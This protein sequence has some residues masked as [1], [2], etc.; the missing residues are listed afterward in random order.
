[1]SPTKKT[2]AAPKKSPRK[3]T[4]PKKRTAKKK[5]PSRKTSRDE[6][7]SDSSNVIK[8]ILALTILLLFVISAAFTAIHVFKQK[9]KPRAI[10]KTEKLK[11]NVYHAPVF[12]VYP[13]EESDHTKPT[14]TI[15]APPKKKPMVS[16]IIDDLGYD[17]KIARKFLKINQNITFSILPHSPHQK[18]IAKD[19]KNNGTEILLH[20]PME[21]LKYPAI[22][23]GPGT[24]FSSMSPDELIKQ[25][26][27]NLDAVPFIIGV[28]NHMGSKITT[29]AP[30]IYQVFSILK[31]RGLFF[32][33]SRTTNKSVC[34][35]SAR[36][37][38]IPF[39]ERSVFLDNNQNKEAVKKQLL[40]L[41]KIAMRDGIAVGI[42]H[43]YK[44]TYE[45]LETELPDFSKKVNL[46]PIS[47]IIKINQS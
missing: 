30:Q 31:K 40:R 11:K 45:V 18:R 4:P 41:L 8:S 46:V 14:P 13:D 47:H 38:K 23:S 1:M 15:V 43:P 25:L 6:T 3:K 7:S 17:R 36:L 37:F 29:N 5:A 12:E 26:E 19:A 16:I 28:N 21:P 33:D 24:L 22:D 27:I 39:A 42:G 10:H 44:I 35:P 2:K 9:Q 32:I 34:K 20:L